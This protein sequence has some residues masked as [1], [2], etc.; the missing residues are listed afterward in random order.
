M[1]L[2]FCWP[3]LFFLWGEGKAQAL[4]LGVG[5]KEEHRLGS[6]EG[7]VVEAD[8]LYREEMDAQERYR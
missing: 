6:G 7:T 1:D 3:G 4:G 5:R 2:S 8:H